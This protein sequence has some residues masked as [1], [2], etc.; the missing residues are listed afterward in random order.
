[1]PRCKYCNREISKFDNDICP[2]CGG[3]HP[4]EEGYAT[5]DVTTAFAKKEQIELYK[6]KSKSKYRNLCFGLG[7]FG[8]HNFYL[9]FKKKGLI[10]LI[11]TLL[12]IGT[13]GT[14]LF[15]FALKS[16][17][18]VAYLIPII[19]LYI[20]YLIDGLLINGKNDLKD[21]EGVFLR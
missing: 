4:I 2:H 17:P 9:G 19:A 21:S 18:F 10:N 1:M 20:F 7:L 16:L 12:I 13:I 5:M 14:L 8:V 11:S 6:S 15:L 3:K